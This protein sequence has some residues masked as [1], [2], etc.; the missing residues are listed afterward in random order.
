MDVRRYVPFGS[1]SLQFALFVTGLSL[2]IAGCG[3][4][5][6]LPKSLAE[7]STSFGY[8][9]LDPLPVSTWAAR[10]CPF[11]SSFNDAVVATPL[12]ATNAPTPATH[13]P[14]FKPMLVSLPDQAVRMA[15]GQFNNS[16]SLS[17]GPIKLS[18]ENQVYQVV[19]DYIDVDTAQMQVYILRTIADPS[20]PGKD[21]IVSIY[22]TSITGPSKYRVAWDPSGDAYVES[23]IR[24]S[25]ASA[26]TAS[27]PAS[28]AYQLPFQV[29][30]EEHI[31]KEGELVSIPVY[32]G[33]GLRLIATVNVV[34][35]GVNLSSLSS[36]AADVQAGSVNGTLQVQTLGITGKAVATNLPL[37]SELNQTTIQNAIL[38]IGAIKA[39]LYD[40]AVSLSDPTNASGTHSGITQNIDISVTPRIVGIYNTA[41]GGEQVVNGVISVLASHQIIWHRPCWNAWTN[42]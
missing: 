11:T 24:K 17:Y 16:G 10:S 40:N 38:S 41:G 6:T 21:K 2:I 1:R 27:P 28:E 33:I 34:K 14:P 18:E 9:P 29:Q 3:L 31:Q 25:S 12:I 42:E 36:L 30:D 20:T 4:C 13:V 26:N 5:P 39:I 8:V 15:I 7:Q 37:P 35:G 19:L 32:V 22:D 23:A